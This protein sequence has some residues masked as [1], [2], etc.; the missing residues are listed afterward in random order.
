MSFKDAVTVV[1]TP[2]EL[3][4][5]ILKATEA[6]DFRPKP[7]HLHALVEY[8]NRGKNDKIIEQLLKRTREKHWAVVLKSL[9]TI[10]TLLSRGSLFFSSRLSRWESNTFGHLSGYY[11]KYS[12]EMSEVIRQ[13]SSYLGEKIYTHNR[14]GKDPLRGSLKQSFIHIQST[15][16]QEMFILFE[17]LLDQAGSLLKLDLP[18]DLYN[19]AIVYQIY[20]LLFGDCVRL[21]VLLNQVAIYFLDI[22]IKLSREEAVRAFQHLKT[23]CSHVEKMKFF[24]EMGAKLHTFLE[25]PK[26]NLLPSTLIP[27]LK[28]YLEETESPAKFKSPVD[29]SNSIRT[30]SSGISSTY[31]QF[32]VPS[33]RG[34]PQVFDQSTNSQYLKFRDHHENLLSMDDSSF[35]DSSN[36]NYNA[37][38]N[39]NKLS[40]QEILDLFDPL[41]NDLYPS[42]AQAQ[43]DCDFARQS[44]EAP[45]KLETLQEPFSLP[46]HYRNDFIT[47]SQQINASTTE[48]SFSDRKDFLQSDYD[49]AEKDIPFQRTSLNP[50][51]FQSPSGSEERPTHRNTNPFL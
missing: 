8:S 22:F 48:F 35:Q 27:S 12:Y 44:F 45:P 41:R 39:T 1:T 30:A 36:F 46:S 13:Y 14:L 2:S 18:P 17:L 28:K 43:N 42:T 5:S 7:K 21:Y 24:T 10:H 4:R 29:Q 19:S 49:S 38:T 47:S 40:T 37:R 23:F 6:S 11:D 51:D 20:F 3:S 50:F 26:F 16:N 34:L 31:S 15:N 25:V 33:G 32:R 9:I